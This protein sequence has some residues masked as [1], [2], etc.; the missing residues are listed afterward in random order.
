MQRPS[1]M[2]PMPSEKMHDKIMV[3]KENRH[4]VRR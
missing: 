2:E 1:N 4:A 3:W